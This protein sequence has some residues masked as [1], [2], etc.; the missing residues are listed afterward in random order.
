[1]QA[2][3][4]ST[5]TSTSIPDTYSYTRS[6]STYYSSTPPR[7]IRREQKKHRAQ[8]LSKKELLK[9]R[10]KRIALET[11]I[12]ILA[13]RLIQLK[14]EHQ[15]NEKK[16]LSK[17]TL[18]TFKAEE[19]Y[20]QSK[21]K[22]PQFQD[23]IRKYI[24]VKKDLAAAKATVDLLHEKI[25]EIKEQRSAMLE[26]FDD[27]SD[28]MNFND[29]CPQI[30]YSKINSFNKNPE[31]D[32]FGYRNKLDYLRSL[33]KEINDIDCNRRN[34][35][36]LPKASLELSRAS[37]A[38]AKLKAIG[39]T[40]VK[41][42][43]ENMREALRISELNVKKRESEVDNLL[44][45]M[46]NY[47]KHHEAELSKSQQ[48]LTLFEESG[49]KDL[50]TLQKDIENIRT[51]IDRTASIFDNI[52][53]ELDELYDKEFN[54]NHIEEFINGEE[55]I[56]E[57]ESKSNSL[58][59]ENEHDLFDF[60]DNV[61]QQEMGYAQKSLLEQK[62]ELLKEIASLK[63][64]FETIKQQAKK[65]NNDLKKEVYSLYQHLS[66]NKKTLKEEINSLNTSSSS[67][68]SST[69]SLLAKNIDASISNLKNENI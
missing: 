60:S 41:M 44:Q 3:S 1:M 24:S 46:K 47:E 13:R 34:S 39:I 64:E 45:R 31:V 21:I 7:K 26:Q 20:N 8:K 15:K 36:N 54:D 56:N 28:A 35:H 40:G 49:S 51:N 33:Y 32:A 63:T 61:E 14:K 19:M 18:I 29:Y 69:L 10:N 50:E 16:K 57:E 30:N 22:E 59:E 68:L 11:K 42:E 67:S 5:R 25:H 9:L 43:I 2:S 55:F 58:E 17:A 23:I 12:K 62:D 65:R 37:F 6:Y 53:S 52:Q 66:S 48:R 38:E 27:I 4:S